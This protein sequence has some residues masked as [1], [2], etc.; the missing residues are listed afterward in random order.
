MLQRTIFHF[1]LRLSHRSERRYD[2]YIIWYMPIS[3]F[4]AN[5]NANKRLYFSIFILYFLSF[6]A[7]KMEWLTSWMMKRCSNEAIESN[8]L[9]PN[10]QSNVHGG[11]GIWTPLCKCGA[12]ANVLV[13][14]VL[15]QSTHK[16]SNML[17]SKKKRRKAIVGKRCYE[18]RTHSY[19]MNHSVKVQIDDTHSHDLVPFTECDYNRC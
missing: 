15:A 6:V 2:S 7:M 17:F 12:A 8:T 19:I 18:H 4:L 3:D 10:R 13:Q 5:G 14:F 16:F 9:N 1:Q 11:F